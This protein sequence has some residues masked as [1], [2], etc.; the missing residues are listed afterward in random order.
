MAK[1]T[2]GIDVSKDRLDAFWHSQDA[3]L[4]LPNTVEGF[5]QLCTWLGKNKGVLVVFEATGAYHRG[6]ERYL[7]LAGQP[8]IK[9][10]PKQARRFAQAIGRLAKT[11][12][13]DARMLARMGVVL[14]L[15]PQGIEG[16]DIHDLRELLTARIVSHGM[17]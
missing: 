15:A 12:S 17:V 7:S 4:S 8:F 10:N 3:A 16:E 11:D 13:V 9:V 2:I 5:A 6:L 14:D 1:D